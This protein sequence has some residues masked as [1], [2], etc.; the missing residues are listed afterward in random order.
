[1]NDGEGE[2]DKLPSVLTDHRTVG[3]SKREKKHEI[4]ISHREP[5]SL[6]Q[7]LAT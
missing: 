3:Q 5:N 6:A 4:Q 2:A 7:L 1:M